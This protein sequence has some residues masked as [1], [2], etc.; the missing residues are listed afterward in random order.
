MKAFTKCPCKL[1]FDFIVHISIVLYPAPSL[2]VPFPR[3]IE[4]ISLRQIHNVIYYFMGLSISY[5]KS[6]PIRKNT[7][8]R[9]KLLKGTAFLAVIMISFHFVCE[10][11]IKI[12]CCW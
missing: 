8:S 2:L 4:I 11:G 10:K 12:R 5:S 1:I 3:K 9:V 6:M 7:T